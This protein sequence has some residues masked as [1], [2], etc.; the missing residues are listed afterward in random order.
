MAARRECEKNPLRLFYTSLTDD[1]L[2][3]AYREIVVRSP[4]VTHEVTLR[5][6]QE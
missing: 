3:I 5:K 4:N 2:Q 1:D 6:V